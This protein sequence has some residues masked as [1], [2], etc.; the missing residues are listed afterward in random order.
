MIR[1][2]RRQWIEIHDQPWCPVAVRDGATDC[3]KL[4]AVIGRQFDGAIDPLN[5]VLAETGDRY[6]VDLCAGGGGPWLGLHN[7]L[8]AGG[9]PPIVVLTDL[10]PNQA[11]MQRAHRRTR[12]H[13]QYVK[14]P[15]D[16]AAVSEDLPGLRTLFTAFHHFDP[17]AARAVLQDAVTANQAVAIFEQTQRSLFG[18]I[19]ML[20]LFPL[21]LLATPLLHPFRWSR[22]FWTYVIPA[23][24]LVLLVDGIVSCLRTYTQC[25]LQAMIDSLDGPRYTWRYGRARTLLSPLGMNYLVGYPYARGDETGE[26]GA[27]EVGPRVAR[28]T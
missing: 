24:P 6:I 26:D 23:I 28:M 3:L 19:F 20:L 12:G 22:L 25:E 15:V 11:A 8:D 17:T 5:A 2:S 4:F 7:R 1:L 14:R 21:A 18:L 10:F 16:A 27:G 13:I 9:A